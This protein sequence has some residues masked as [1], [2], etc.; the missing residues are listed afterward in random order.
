MCEAAVGLN[1]GWSRANA[2]WLRGLAK[3]SL[4]E[5][6]RFA[7]GSRVVDGVMQPP[8][9]DKLDLPSNPQIGG[10]D[11]D[12]ARLLDHVALNIMKGS[13]MT[14]TEARIVTRAARALESAASAKTAITQKELEQAVNRLGLDNDLNTPDFR[15]AEII[16]ENA[17]LWREGAPTDRKAD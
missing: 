4:S 5:T 3:S 11:S 17:V 9:F 6:V 7:D 15:V 10:K 2:E 1:R 14:S 13:H 8:Q 16:F 12:L